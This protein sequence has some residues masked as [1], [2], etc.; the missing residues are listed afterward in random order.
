MF[1]KILRWSLSLIKLQDWKVFQMF[2]CEI[3]FIFKNTFFYRTPLVAASEVNV[4]QFLGLFVMISFLF[5][6]CGFR[7]NPN[8][9]FSSNGDWKESVHRQNVLFER[10]KFPKW[11]SAF[12][13]LFHKNITDVFSR[14]ILYWNSSYHSHQSWYIVFVLLNG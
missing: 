10:L 5:E 13:W 6:T 2:S 4:F 14:L 12:R 1:F 9:L 7:N 8:F 11:R 3:Y